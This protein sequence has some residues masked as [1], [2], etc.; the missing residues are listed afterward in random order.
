M[1]VGN[2]AGK[3]VLCENDT[4]VSTPQKKERMNSAA[5][6]IMRVVTPSDSKT[7][8]LI[9]VANKPHRKLDLF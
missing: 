6:Q 7:L 9:M 3:T 5:S 2:Q 1:G 4:P 8:L